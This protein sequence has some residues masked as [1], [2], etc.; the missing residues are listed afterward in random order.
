MQSAA[1]QQS[2]SRALWERSLFVSINTLHDYFQPFT[3]SVGTAGCEPG[4]GQAA[5]KKEKEAVSQVTGHVLGKAGDLIYSQ[6][7][8]C[9]TS[10]SVPSPLSLR[11]R[12]AREHHH[13]LILLLFIASIAFIYS[14][15]CQVSFSSS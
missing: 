15:W 9:V 6:T 1:H 10:T 5:V 4:W 11:R 3:V 8:A 7:V 13:K 12:L 2:P 14:H